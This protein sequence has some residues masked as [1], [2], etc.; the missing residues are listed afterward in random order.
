MD[1]TNLEKTEDIRK[2]AIIDR[3]LTLVPSGKEITHSSG[4]VLGEDERRIHGVGFAVHNR[5]L[6]RIS[7][8]QGISER[9]TVMEMETKTGKAHF[10]STYAQTLT[11][12]NEKKYQFYEKLQDAINN[13][14]KADHLFLMGDFNARVGTENKVWPT[15]FGP[16]GLGKIN[17]NGQRL[18]EF[19]TNNNPCITNT[20][21]SGKGKHK[22]SWCHPRSGHWHQIDFI[23]VRKKDANMAS[24][25]GNIRK[26][27]EN[28]RVAIGPTA[29]KVAPLKSATG[30]Q[31]IDKKK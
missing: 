8:P 13:V 19:C 10:N 4:R 7:T 18:L 25:T 16:F 6:N 14:P 22:V 29:N 21:Y 9:I 15:C 28:I 26:M 12:E 27:S 31:L 1:T 30:E 5:L 20:F 24:D 11:T 3:E 17:E 23:I 2:T